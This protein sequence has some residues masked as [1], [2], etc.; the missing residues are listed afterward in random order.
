MLI[1]KKKKKAPEDNKILKTEINGYFQHTRLLKPLNYQR[2]TTTVSVRDDT[3]QR[4]FQ[5]KPLCDCCK[6]SHVNDLGNC[7]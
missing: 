3:L 7:D 6:N 2:P 5:V 4:S 1:F